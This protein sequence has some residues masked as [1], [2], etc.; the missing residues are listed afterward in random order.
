MQILSQLMHFFPDPLQ[1]PGGSGRTIQRMESCYCKETKLVLAS[2]GTAPTGFGRS[3]VHVRAE[4]GPKCY[5]MAVVA[6]V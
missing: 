4:L 5:C 1:K 6:L 2:A 3:C